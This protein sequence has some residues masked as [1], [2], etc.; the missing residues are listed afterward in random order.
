MAASPPTALCGVQ[1]FRRRSVR[2]E[3]LWI[4]RKVLEQ[5]V[6]DAARWFPDETGGAFM[7]YEAEGGLV[8]TDLI[9]AGP[10][11]K[12]SP[13][14]FTPDA[15]FQLADMAR[16]YHESGRIHTYVGDWH[17]HPDGSPGYSGI[18]RAALKTIARAPGA[19]CPKPLMVILGLGE[20]WEAIAWCHKPRG[21]WSHVDAMAIVLY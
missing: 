12:R 13:T 16:I 7:G 1:L 20:S 15:D 10:L 14:S 6:L 9:D 8:V 3:R 18:D 17:S 21:L 4:P 2:P 11:A 5:M 19:R